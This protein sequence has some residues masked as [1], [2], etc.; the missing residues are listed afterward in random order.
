MPALIALLG[1]LLVAATGGAR[2]G[3][4]VCAL[5]AIDG[6]PGRMLVGLPVANDPPVSLAYRT[7]GGEARMTTELWRGWAELRRAAGRPVERVM[8]LFDQDMLHAETTL[9][10]VMIAVPRGHL[11][12]LMVLVRTPTGVSVRVFDPLLPGAPPELT[13]ACD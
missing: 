6:V 4:L 2:A 1:L 10:G 11:D 13:G 7:E 5:R 3:T 12:G 8:V 9:T